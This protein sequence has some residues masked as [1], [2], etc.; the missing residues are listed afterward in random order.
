MQIFLSDD[1]VAHLT[2]KQR[3][4]AQARALLSMGIPFDRRP[5][6]SPVVRRSVFESAPQAKTAEPKWDAA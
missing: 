4:S 6:G 2:G 5:D 3:P 1:E